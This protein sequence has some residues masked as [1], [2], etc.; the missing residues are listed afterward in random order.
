LTESFGEVPR[1]PHPSG[2]TNGSPSAPFVR[3]FFF[4]AVWPFAR[5]GQT[6]HPVAARFGV[7]AGLSFPLLAGDILVLR[8]LVACSRA[9]LESRGNTREVG[10]IL[11]ADPSKVKSY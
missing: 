2:L 8:Q 1:A 11:A 9:V 7:A 3:L 6:E 5:Q 10:I 4:L